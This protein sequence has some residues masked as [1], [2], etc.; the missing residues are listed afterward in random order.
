M[1]KKE[2][3]KTDIKKQ[4]AKFVIVLILYLLFLLWVKSWLGLIVVPFIY[5]A[6]ISKKINWKWWQDAEGPTRTIM[7]WV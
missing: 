1:M 3:K 4:W 7:S 2:K 5:D 6:Y